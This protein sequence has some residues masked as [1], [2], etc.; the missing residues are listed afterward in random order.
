MTI[1]NNN[2]FNLF[3][4]TNINLKIIKITTKRKSIH[5]I[6]LKYN[7]MIKSINFNKHTREI[8]QS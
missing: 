1:L 6:K 2:N 4:N 3:V 7:L 8:Y 5:K